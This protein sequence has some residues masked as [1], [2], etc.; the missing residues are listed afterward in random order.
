MPNKPSAPRKTVRLG[1]RGSPLALIQAEMVKAAL[2]A[3][4]GWDAAA[5]TIVTVKTDG[6]RIQDRALAELGGKALWTKTL[7][8]ALADGKID[9][10]VHSMK[11]VETLR[12]Q[13][14]TLA[15]MLERAA[16]EDKLIGAPSIAALPHGACIGTASPRRAA[17]L[18]ALRSDLRTTLLRGNVA[19]RLAK[20]ASGVIDA[21]L[22]AAAGL[23]RLGQSDTGALIPVETMLPAVAQGA[24]GIECRTDDTEMRAALAAIDHA[25]THACVL[26]ERAL[27]R[28]LGGSCHSPV[29]ALARHEGDAIRLRAQIFSEDGAHQVAGEV[30]LPEG[31][32]EPAVQFGAQLLEHAHPAIRA[33]FCQ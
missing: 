15:A 11:D 19:S 9:A 6:D 10:A 7:D 27:L 25:P 21:T 8:K 14:I 29:A 33:L 5:V 30:L 28:G 24:V 1:S 31:K 12:P 18:K 3:A 2:C 22:L 16:V 23:D 20:V 13:A 32:P 26:A 4:H 17:Q